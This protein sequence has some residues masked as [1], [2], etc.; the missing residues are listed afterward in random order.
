MM[1]LFCNPTKLH[2]PRRR[3]LSLTR[4]AFVRSIRMRVEVSGEEKDEV[5]A[6]IRTQR[7]EDA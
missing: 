5:L 6:S 3:A 1:G 7:A 4:N 2:G